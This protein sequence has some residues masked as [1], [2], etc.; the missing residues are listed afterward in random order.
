MYFF[1]AYEVRWDTAKVRSR[2]G[3]MGK[4][5]CKGWV[6]SVIIK[7][8]KLITDIIT[9]RHWFYIYMYNVKTCMYTISKLYQM[10]NLECKA[11]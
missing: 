8:K 9:C 5:R 2:I 10:I 6:N 1:T 7:V 3:G 11:T 4:L